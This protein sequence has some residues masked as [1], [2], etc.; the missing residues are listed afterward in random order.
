MM[1]L[2]GYTLS[3]IEN[4]IPFEREI[5]VKLL[6]KYIDEKNTLAANELAKRGR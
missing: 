2:H 4:M 5:Y 6:N 3:E 1:Q